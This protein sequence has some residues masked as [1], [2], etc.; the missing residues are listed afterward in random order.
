MF[1]WKRLRALFT[2]SNFH[3]SRRLRRRTGS[4]NSVASVE[5]LE[6]RLVLTAVTAFEQYFV[7]LINQARANPAATATKYGINLNEGLPAGTISTAPKQPLALNDALQTAIVGHVQD[8][9]THDY[10]SHTG[11]DGSTPFTRMIAAG[12]TPWTSLGENLAVEWTTGAVNVQAFVDD[13]FK[14]LFIDATEPGRGHRL[15]ILNGTYQE[16][17]SAV[18]TGLFQGANAVQTGNDFGSKNQNSFLTGIAFTDT[19]TVNNFY[20]VGEGLRGVSVVA[21]NAAGATFQTATN[22]AGGYQLQLAQGIYSVTFSGNGIKSPIVKNFFIGT[23]NVEVDANTRIDVGVGGPP[24]LSGV[25]AI[26]Y[27]ENAAAQPIDSAITISDFGRTTLSTAT[28]TIPN[29]VA[30]QDVIGFVPN[31]ATMGNIAITSNA[32]G[33][34]RL[35]SAGAKAT[36]AQWQTA[37]RAVKYSNSSNAPSTATRHVTIVVDDGKSVNHLSNT[38]ST[39]ISVTAVN[40]PPV[41]KPNTVSTAKNTPYVFRVTDFGFSDPLDSPHNA[42]AFVK[43]TTVPTKGSLMDNGKLVKN[44]ASV[45]IADITNGKFTFIP[46]N[47]GSGTPYTSFTFQVRDNGG[48]AN[49]GKD[50]DPTA[51]KMTINVTS[52]N[53]SPVGKPHTV[54]TLQNAYVFKVADFGFSDPNDNPANKLLAVKIT[55]LPAVGTLTDNGQ[56]ITPGKFIPVADII[57]GKLKYTLA[58]KPKG[59]TSTSFTFQVQDNGGTANGGRD[60]DITP[61]LMTIKFS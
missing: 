5:F 9:I 26:N 21:K 38:L 2:S 32:N 44:G 11:F 57:A 39:S 61:R 23:Q 54:T 25:H 14:N 28:I 45:P 47:N 51:R 10:F 6:P 30:G 20:N 49:G 15:N 33:V 29:F 43:I 22:A 27:I 12:Y 40:D 35:T 7:E 4:R 31:A 55:T 18:L 56:T 8:E 48:T 60:T 58:S 19:V 16:V 37:L 42:F 59:V 13:E 53:A 36:L 41:G 46:A 34:L 52:A 17:G 50:T 3:R 24:V 1:I